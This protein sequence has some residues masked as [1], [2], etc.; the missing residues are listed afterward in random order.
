MLKRNL[1]AFLCATLLLASATAIAADK[2]Y[3][4]TG[5]V[6]EVSPTA[7]TVKKGEETWQI[8]R[9]GSTKISGDIKVGAKVTIYYKMVATEVEV[10]SAKGD[11][12]KK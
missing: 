8:S 12:K 7:I 4:V 5:P 2:T 6:L 10:K 11:S 9:D 1:N 3:Q